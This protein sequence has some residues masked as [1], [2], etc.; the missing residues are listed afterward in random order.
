MKPVNVVRPGSRM[1][2]SESVR[3]VVGPVDELAWLLEFLQREAFTP[4]EWLDLKDQA[5]MFATAHAGDHVELQSATGSRAHRSKNP[6]LNAAGTPEEDVHFAAGEDLFPLTD[7]QRVH[8]ELRE[9]LQGMA[10]VDIPLYR[11]TGEFK[12]TATVQVFRTAHGEMGRA[13]KFYRGSHVG[14]FWMRAAD[15][16][17]QGWHRIRVCARAGCGRL[18]VPV[19][20]QVFCSQECSRSEQWKRFVKRN[21]DR[22]RDYHEEYKRRVR[23]TVGPAKVQNRGSRATSQRKGTAK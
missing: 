15:V 18:F 7:L 17:T 11:W 23:K 5:F 10:R 13:D 22:G 12:V 1:V 2:V 14:I 6:A 16:L 8:R 20:R 4:G 19:R 3:T 9:R 21:P